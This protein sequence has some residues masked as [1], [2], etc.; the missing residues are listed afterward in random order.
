LPANDIGGGGDPPAL[1][2][3]PELGRMDLKQIAALVG[4]ASMN[5]DSG[6]K[7]GYRKTI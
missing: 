6:R 5:R 1:A 7:R 4:V 3:L 2:D